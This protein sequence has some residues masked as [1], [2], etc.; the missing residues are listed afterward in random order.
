MTAAMP[1]QATHDQTDLPTLVRGGIK[2]G[3]IQSALVAAF[4]VLQVRLDGVKELVVC[5]AILLIGV[6]AT[7]VLPGRW[8]RARTIEG[9]A[10]AAGIGLA[11]A[12]VF[13]IVD[14]ALL[15]RIGIYTNRWLE[16][17]GGSNWWYHPVWWMVCT[18]MTWQGAWIQA[19]QAAKRG[20]ASPVLLVAGTV[21]LAAVCLAVAVVLHVPN[22]AWG[23]GGLGVAVL[24]ALALYTAVSAL[25]VPRR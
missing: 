1:M 5:G 22:A 17:G 25:G 9:I 6:A 23:L 19:H 21:V 4:A 13:L 2:L 20:E 8:T 16:I 7:I 24:P 14:V 10:G 11:A 12:W 3:L 18:F 15:Q